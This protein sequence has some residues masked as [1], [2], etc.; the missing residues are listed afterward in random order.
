VSVPG[1]TGAGYIIFD[2]LTGDGA[3]KISGGGNGG[4]LKDKFD[5]LQQFLTNF[6]IGL[7][8]IG[9]SVKSAIVEA[10]NTLI[11]V[12]DILQNCEKPFAYLFAFVAVGFLV[13][14]L[15][16]GILVALIGVQSLSVSLGATALSVNCCCY[17]WYNN[18]ALSIKV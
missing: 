11:T 13:A 10:I 7:S 18:E 8:V 1:Y 9:E 2:P 4:F 15:T 14:S 5:K 17:R 12:I 16:P 6:S 3:Y